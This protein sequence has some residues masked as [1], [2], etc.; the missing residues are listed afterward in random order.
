MRGSS[1]KIM[2]FVELYA[3]QVLWRRIFLSTTI[4]FFLT[5]VVLFIAWLFTPL[6][7]TEKDSLLLY[8]SQRY[9]YTPLTAKAAYHNN[10]QFTTIAYDEMV[11]PEVERIISER[12]YSFFTV[13]SIKKVDSK[14]YEVSGHRF[15]CKK[16]NE[17]DNGCLV[18]VNDDAKLN[19]GVSGGKFYETFPAAS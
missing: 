8:V 15:I 16:V 14:L 6:P 13:L 19:I 17:A 18:V 7:K 2:D 12:I 10:L 1:D 5:T 9:T 4:L 11:R 3:P